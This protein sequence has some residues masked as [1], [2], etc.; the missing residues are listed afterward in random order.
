MRCSV[1]GASA[2]QRC[3]PAERPDLIGLNLHD[4][5][6]AGRS[7]VEPPTSTG[8]PLKPASDGVPGNPLHPSDRGD[9]DTL[10]SEGRDLSNVVRELQS[11]GWIERTPEGW[12]LIPQ[13]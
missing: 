7:V 13:P 10:D 5:E 9:A 4:S 3:Y 11:V 6:S 1:P 8:R 2:I 12:R